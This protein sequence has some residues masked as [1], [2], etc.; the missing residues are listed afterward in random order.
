MQ[1]R[2]GHVLADDRRRLEQLLVRRRQPG[3]PRRQDQLHRGGNLDRLDRPGQSIRAA[4]TEERPSFHERLD[5]FLDEERIAAL[6][7]EVPEWLQPRVVA[8]EGMQK[9]ARTL[10]RE[11]VEP[12]LGVRGLAPPTMLVFGPIIGEQEQ[13][14]RGQALDQ[15]VEQRLCRRIDP[16]QVLDNHQERLN[17]ALVA[18][19]LP[20][21]VLNPSALLAWVEIAPRR[22]VDG[23]VEEREQRREQRS[24]R[25]VP[26]EER[27]A[28]LRPD[29][30]RRVGVLDREVASQ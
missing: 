22:I 10:G 6:D 26:G 19:E 17:P 3:D 1:Q 30:F 13:P 24:Q 25:F 8:Q 9:L 28:H 2:E 14:D 15:A 27:L 11:R 21:R 7:Q 29:R 4:L 5:A 20:D 23:D 18:Q 12:Q 16:L